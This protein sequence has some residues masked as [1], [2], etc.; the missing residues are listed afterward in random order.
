M[1]FA[2]QPRLIQRLM[3]VEDEPLTAFESEYLL[4]EA[5]YTVVGTVDR[6]GEAL[7]MIDREPLDLVLLDVCLS[8]GG[9]GLDVA[10]AAKRRGIAV[11]FVSAFCPADA[12]QFAIGC[13]A[14]PYGVRDLLVAVRAVDAR[15]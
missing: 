10:R 7:D 12:R 5:G 8:G 4:G 3:V 11:L 9:D 13:L 6:V 1:L 15:P 2:H 14:K